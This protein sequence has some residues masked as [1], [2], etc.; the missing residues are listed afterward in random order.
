[1][2]EIMF[3]I[4]RNIVVLLIVF[5]LLEMF[6]PR[7]DFRPFLNMVI[8]LVLMLTL[9][10]PLWTLR[11]LPQE[12]VM[13]AGERHRLQ[14]EEGD[15]RLYRLRQLNQGLTLQRYRELLAG[16]IAE[17]L[18]AEGLQVVE[19]ALEMV[20]EPGHNA[21][22]QLLAV[23]VLAAALNPAVP[24]VKK[25]PEI[26]ISLQGREIARQQEYGEAPWMA[27][28][29]DRRLASLLAESLGLAEEKIEVR[30]IKN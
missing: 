12:P 7:G 26:R 30:V 25:V 22:G 5:S 10:G 21:Y 23:R 3:D 20:E 14:P 8:G 1:M 15:K 28:V 18:R 2:L 13:P 16:K 19:Q 27:G 6:L 17:V 29:S 9:L 4:T 24:P 11:Q